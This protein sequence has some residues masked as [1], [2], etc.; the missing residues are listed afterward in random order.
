MENLKTYNQILI[1]V[2]G[3]LFFVFL[4]LSMIS[5]GGMLFS[6]LKGSKDSSDLSDNSSGASG[7]TTKAIVMEQIEPLSD[8][9]YS[10]DTP[11]FPEMYLIPISSKEP[12]KEE[13]LFNFSLEDD[14]VSYYNVVLYM[15]DSSSSQVL[16]D[17][18]VC[19][20]GRISATSASKPSVFFIG[21]SKDTNENGK[22]DPSDRS[23]IFVLDLLSRKVRKLD[24]EKYHFLDFLYQGEPSDVWIKAMEDQNFDQKFDEGIDPEVILQFDFEADRFKPLIGAGDIKKLEKLLQ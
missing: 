19:L 9:Y 4:V 17:Y 24:H 16:F 1:A 12:P 20:T 14:V 7:A 23:E 18:P 21:S 13:D 6:F 2:A 22:I 3:T 15:P 11:A 8:S 5:F 10:Y